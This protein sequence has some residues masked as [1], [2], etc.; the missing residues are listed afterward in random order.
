MGRLRTYLV[1]VGGALM[2]LGL[3]LMLIQGQPALAQEETQPLKYEGSSECQSCHRNVV[4]DHQGTNHALALVQISRSQDPILGDFTQG[5]DVRMVQLPGEDAVRPFTADDVAYVMGAGRYIQTYVYE[6]E[7]NQYRVLPARWNVTESRWEPLDLAASW[8]DPAYEFVQSCAGC[9]TTGLNVEE[10]EWVDDGVMCEAC[11][12]PAE[13]HLSVVDDAGRR[14]S[15]EELAAIRASINPGIDSQVCGACH[16]R[17]EV[18]EGDPAFPVDYRPGGTLTEQGSYLPF[19]PDDPIHWYPTGHASHT[20]MQYNEWLASGHPLSLE[21]LRGADN[22]GSECLA[23]HAGEYRI[24]QGQIAASE[25]GDRDGIPPEPLTVASAQYG[26]ACITCHDPHGAA[27]QDNLL[28]DEPYALCTSCHRD[29]SDTEGIHHPVKEMF[30]GTTLIDTIPGV[31]S[32]HFATENGATCTTC[33]MADVPMDGQ[34]RASH[35]MSPIMPGAAL[36]VEALLDTCSPCHA[37]QATPAALQ[38]LIDDTQNSVRMRIEAV[39]AAMPRTAPDWAVQALDFVEGDGSYGMHNFV[40]ADLI[41]DEL[42]ADLGLTG[43]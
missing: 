41:L 35:T 10:G 2:A 14:P 27:D 29:T 38:A 11:H 34:S 33:H 24:V 12:G 19:G 32:A 22:A 8:D 1:L 26:V 17:G 28:I 9:H 16:S 30:E 13:Q 15:D 20:N 36:D 5:E 4:R 43:R 31:P 42:E 25:A 7:R 37:E 23:C 21:T 3:A 18:P 39:R 40:Y 6:V